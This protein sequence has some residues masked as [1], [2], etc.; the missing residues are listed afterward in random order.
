MLIGPSLRAQAKPF[1]NPS[2]VR[3]PKRCR[4][5]NVAVM[6][7]TES[8]DLPLGSPAGQFAVSTDASRADLARL[9]DPSETF[10]V[11]G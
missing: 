8:V 11:W 5:R 1:C 4:D 7:L 9:M 2:R 6:V 10:P 3:H